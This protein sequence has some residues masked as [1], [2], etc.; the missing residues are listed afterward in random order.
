[1]QKLMQE[2]Q[3][4]IVRYCLEFLAMDSKFILKPNSFSFSSYCYLYFYF[5]RPPLELLAC[6]LCNLNDGEFD[7][8]NNISL[9]YKFLL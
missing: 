8:V 1:M 4:H 7:Y 6:G 3:I 5:Y 2:S 9:C